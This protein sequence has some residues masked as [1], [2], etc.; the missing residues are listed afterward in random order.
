VSHFA[1]GPDPEKE[2]ATHR[3]SKRKERLVRPSFPSPPKERKAPPADLDELWLRV[4][5]GAANVAGVRYQL[6]VTVYSLAGARASLGM[7]ELSPEGLEDI[8][9]H[10]VG[11][12]RLLV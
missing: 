1:A 3:K 11:G 10:L 7:T 6:A 8:D 9:C 4:R 5:S 12:M 2:I